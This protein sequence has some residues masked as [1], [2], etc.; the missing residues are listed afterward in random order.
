[1]QHKYIVYPSAIEV[2]DIGTEKYL[3]PE[4][5]RKRFDPTAQPVE[6]IEFRSCGKEYLQFAVPEIIDGR[7]PAAQRLGKFHAPH[8]P[9]VFIVQTQIHVVVL[10]ERIHFSG[11]RI[12]DLKRAIRNDHHRIPFECRGLTL[13]FHDPVYGE[14][15]SQR[16]L[17]GHYAE[18]RRNIGCICVGRSQRFCIFPSENPVY[19]PAVLGK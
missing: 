6:Q 5:Y 9:A 18:H 8:S 7:R 14:G 13:H 4:I 11:S 3:L 16:T 1:M 19:R 12:P 2:I 15:K 10:V 17:L